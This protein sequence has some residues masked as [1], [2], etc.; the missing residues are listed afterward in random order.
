[1]EL[2]MLFVKVV[3][4]LPVEVAKQLTTEQH[5]D[6]AWQSR[7]DWKDFATVERLAKYVTAM[8]GK[9][10]LPTD[11]SASTSPRYD[12][13]EAPMVG[14]EVS[15]GFNGDYYPCGKI[16][17][18]TK[19]WRVTT[20]SGKVFNR[21]RDTGGWRMVGGTWWMVDGVVDERNPHV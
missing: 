1:M 2:Q 19:G 16:T 8:T 10:Y 17:R 5:G 11:A 7:W 15:Y 3:N 12:I 6:R 13:I 14:D 20:D 4:D 9:T 21:V 18:I